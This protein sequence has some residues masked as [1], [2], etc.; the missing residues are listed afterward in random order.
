MSKLLDGFLQFILADNIT[1]TSIALFVALSFNTIITSISN[2]II[3]PGLS[4][5][6]KSKK[7]FNITSVLSNTF[8]F[9]VTGIF[10]YFLLIIPLNEL[11]R[12]LNLIKNVRCPYCMSMVNENATKCP[13]CTSTLNPQNQ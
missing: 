7:P 8:L 11:K 13:S 12:R 9:I 4:Y 1:T 2:G 3:S 10:V 6:S 5:F